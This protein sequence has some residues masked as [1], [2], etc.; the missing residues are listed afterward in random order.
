MTV[1]IRPATPADADALKLRPSDLH[2]ALL[3]VPGK[4]AQWVMRSSIE[5]AT[6]A[7]AADLEGRVIAIA[8]YTVEGNE[9]YPWLMCSAEVRDHGKTL[10]RWARSTLAYLHGLYPQALICNYLHRPNREARAFINHLGFRIL[11]SPGRSEF[12]LFY[13]PPCASTQ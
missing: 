11:P 8:G 1:I 12:D 2:E 9:V 4:S 6:E 13:L 7:V 3:W 5:H 10:L